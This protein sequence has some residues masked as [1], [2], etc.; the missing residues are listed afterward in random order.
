MAWLVSRTNMPGKLMVKAFAGI[1]FVIPS[2]IGTLG[3]IFLLAPNSGQLNK[4]FIL[5]FGLEKPLLNI[6]TMEGLIFVLILADPVTVTLISMP[7]FT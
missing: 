4:L 6:F 3:W 7:S 5:W 1:A 2:F